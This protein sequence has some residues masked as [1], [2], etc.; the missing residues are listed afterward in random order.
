MR[1]AGAILAVLLLALP[2]RAEDVHG[3]VQEAFDHWLSQGAL[4]GQLGTGMRRADGAWDVQV[5]GAAAR[6]ELASVS[7]SITAV[8]VHHLVQ[9]GRL[10]WSDRLPDILG[11]APD[12]SIAAL[13]THSSGLTP[14]ATQDAMPRWLDKAPD[15]AGHFSAQVLEAVN[16]RGIVDTANGAFFYNNENYALLGLVIKAV[17]GQPYFEY[18]K[19]ALDLPEGIAPSPRSGGMQPWGGLVAEPAAYL[20]FLTAHYGPDSV[21]G[22][23]PMAL[24]HVEMAPGVYYG[25]GTVFRAFRGGYNFWHFGALCFP[26]RMDAGSFAVIWHGRV[27]ALALWDGCVN[28]DAMAQLDGALA[29]AALGGAP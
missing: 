2:A 7:K 22:R 4:S 12:V 25:M 18:C 26:R 14:D 6:G 1:Y 20:A 19:A 29:V 24:P 3:A 13:I 11:D 21:I 16:A 15:G 10:F 5:H 9:D 27:A 17:S 28:W 8:C 23:D